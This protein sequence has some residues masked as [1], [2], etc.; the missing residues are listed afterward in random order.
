MESESIENDIRMLYFSLVQQV[1]GPVS[2]HI[3]RPCAHP[4]GQF[5]EENRCLVRAI[6]AKQMTRDYGMLQ[7]CVGRG[8]TVCERAS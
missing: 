8:R 7:Q 6:A 4:T 5:I 2:R 3:P 1:R